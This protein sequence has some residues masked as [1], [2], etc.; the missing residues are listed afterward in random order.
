MEPEDQRFTEK[1]L[2]R[3]IAEAVE[4]ESRDQQLEEETYTYSQLVE[5]AEGAGI[6]PKYLKAP[7]KQL[8]KEKGGLERA[9]IGRMVGKTGKLGKY[10]LDGFLKDYLG[11]YFALPTTSRKEGRDILHDPVVNFFGMAGFISYAAT[12]GL[13]I[14]SSLPENLHPYAI[15]LATLST[16]TQIGSGLYEWHRAEKKKLIEETNGEKK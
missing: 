9:A 15:S 14:T 16:A 4:R 2:N 6:D 13:A 1:G 7:T 10:I 8:V 11:I 12:L 3:I 5:A